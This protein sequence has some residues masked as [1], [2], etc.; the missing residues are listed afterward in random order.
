[1][2]KSVWIR[3]RRT[4]STILS[5]NMFTISLNKVF[6]NSSTNVEFK[7]LCHMSWYL[8]KAFPLWGHWYAYFRGDVCPLVQSMDGY[9]TYML[10]YLYAM[11]SSD[12]PLVLHLLTAWPSRQSN[13]S[14]PLIQA[15]TSIGGTK[16]QDR[17]HSTMC[18]DTEW[19]MS[20]AVIWYLLFY[21][22]CFS[23]FYWEN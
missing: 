9:L 15:N 4:H 1:M 16:T 8:F 18:A 7:H 3:F 23:L 11:D 12:S 19:S 22:T 2:C 14:D 10:H 20:S 21:V 6:K 17:V 13:I 5:Q